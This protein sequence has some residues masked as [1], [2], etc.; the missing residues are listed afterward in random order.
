MN[1]EEELASVKKKI[2]ETEAKISTNEVERKLAKDHGDLEEVSK[3][4]EKWKI[5]NDQLAKWIAYLGD[6]QKKEN[7]LLEQGKD[8]GKILCCDFLLFLFLIG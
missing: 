4:D 7:I 2:A 5:L 6:L 8:R 1:L 3:L